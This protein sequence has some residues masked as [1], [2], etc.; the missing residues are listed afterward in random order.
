M[1]T[2]P[3]DDQSSPADLARRRDEAARTA[4]KPLKS[5]LGKSAPPPRREPKG[6]KPGR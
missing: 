3:T 1:V 4:P 2:K 6:G 5:Y